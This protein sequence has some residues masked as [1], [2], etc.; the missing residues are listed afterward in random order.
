MTLTYM[1]D[2][3]WVKVKYHA[4]YLGQMSFHSKYKHTYTQ[5]HIYS[6]PVTLPAH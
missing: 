1:H 4:E 2:L 3:D 5:T 6:G